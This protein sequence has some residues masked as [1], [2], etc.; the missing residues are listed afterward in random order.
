MEEDSFTMNVVSTGSNQTKSQ[1]KQDKKAEKK[2]KYLEK[3]LLKNKRIRDDQTNKKENKP[4]NYNNSKEKRD[5]KLNKDNED[6]TIND[7]NELSLHEGTENNQQPLLETDNQ[8]D[9]LNQF[10]NK[11][12]NNKVADKPNKFSTNKI[13]KQKQQKLQ[14]EIDL[15]VNQIIK[16]ED[17]NQLNKLKNGEDDIKKISY[18]DSVFSIKNFEDLQI[19]QY[20]KKA[21]N[22]HNFITMTKIQ[23][24]SI[25]V[26]LE[27]KNVVVKSETGSGKTLAYVIPLYEQLAKLNQETKIT[28]KDGV[29]SVI[30]A[31]THELCMQI[32]ETFNK[33]SSSCINVV[34]GTLM[35][36]Q[37]MDTEKLKIRKGINVII[38]TPGRLLYHINNT[39]NLNFD[40][41]KCIIFDEADRLLDMGFEKDLKACLSKMVKFEQ[42]E[43]VK[44]INPDAFK[45]TKLFLISATIDHKIRQLVSFLMKGFKSVG[46]DIKTEDDV[47]EAPTGLKQYYSIIYDE[48]RLVN[49][50]AFLFNHPNSKIII[51]VSNCDTVNFLQSLFENINFD[52]KH[53]YKQNN[54]NSKNSY[55]SK[56]G[57][58]IESIKF[59]MLNSPIYKLHG[60][61][62][63]EKRKQIFKEFNKEQPGNNIKF[64][65]LLRNS[66]CHRCSC[67]RSRFSSS[68]L[69]N[70]F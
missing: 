61:L 59:K 37:K 25:P 69:D 66:N 2:N 21:L 45:K 62:E 13:N 19:N 8:Y 36:G 58:D 20:L 47:Y 48:F 70:S 18:K 56:D 5:N 11:S 35:G 30:F 26:L 52:T 64:I 33:L 40:N 63:H 4:L 12:K 17:K 1:N 54:I 50:C 39:Q 38:C 49:L 6:K 22:K 53:L 67:K 29:Y 27:H 44:E 34:Y 14:K 7:E 60:K 42:T 46:F 15:E 10:Y 16:E 28:R 32:E 3:K 68:G 43:E 55:K 57:K 65:N 41:L 23:K 24:K 9:E 51:F 31:P